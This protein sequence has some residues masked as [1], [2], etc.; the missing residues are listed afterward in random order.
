MTVYKEIH[1][2]NFEDKEPVGENTSLFYRINKKQDLAGIIIP[3]YEEYEDPE[4]HEI[5]TRLVLEELEITPT[6]EEQE[7]NPDYQ[8]GKMGFDKITVHGIDARHLNITPSTTIQTITAP[9]GVFYNSVTVAPVTSAIDADI[10][11]GNIKHDIEILGTTGTYTGDQPISPLVSNNILILYEYGS[12]H[13][14]TLDLDEATRTL[15][16][17]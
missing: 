4:T 5:K 3:L 17:E 2:Y 11:S 16:N 15:S 12:V 10:L 13:D 14:N 9:E 1:K 8:A 7:F 6:S